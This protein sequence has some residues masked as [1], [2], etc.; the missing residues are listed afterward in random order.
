MAIRGLCAMN[1]EFTQGRR[2]SFGLRSFWAKRVLDASPASRLRAVPTAL[3]IQHEPDGPAGLAADHLAHHGFELRTLQ[4]MSAGSTHSDVEFPDP[5]GYDLILTT[6]SVHSVYDTAGIGSW[7]GREIAMLRSAHDAGVPV[8]GICFGAQALCVAL[9][10]TVEAAPDFEVGWVEF[11][12]DDHSVVPGGPWF[13]WHGD[14][15]R[16]P[17]SIPAIA[18]SPIAAQAFRAGQS[19]AVQFHPEA[20]RTLVEG[21][22]AKCDDDYLRDHHIDVQAVL[23]GFS[24]HGAVAESNLHCMLDRFIEDG[25]R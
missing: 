23:D 16:L 13:T 22:L 3:I 7:I 21:W 5:V 10:G 4:V 17:P 24:R 20:H 14:R 2:V 12:T 25:E 6:G 18:R 8:F 9:G 11:E 15:C 19:M 1:P